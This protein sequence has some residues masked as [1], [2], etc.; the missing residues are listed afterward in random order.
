MKKR[1]K[2]LLKTRCTIFVLY[3]R[4]GFEKNFHLQKPSMYNI[5]IYLYKA[6]IFQFGFVLNAEFMCIRSELGHHFSFT[7]YI[8]STFFDS[9]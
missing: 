9:K 7:L 5:Y 8:L 6:V 4:I 3:R 1:E 2:M